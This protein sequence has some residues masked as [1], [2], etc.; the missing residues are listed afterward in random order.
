MAPMLTKKAEKEFDEKF[1]WNDQQLDDMIFHLDETY[2]NVQS[3]RLK[4][5]INL[6]QT[7]LIELRDMFEGEEIKDRVSKEKIRRLNYDESSRTYENP[8][9]DGLVPNAN[10]LGNGDT[11]IR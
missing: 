6:V 9:V 3:R 11:K 2:Q 7:H 10:Y 1:S 8:S 4:Q 5:K